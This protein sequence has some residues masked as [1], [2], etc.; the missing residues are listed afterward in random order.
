MSP[1]AFEQ[2]SELLGRTFFDFWLTNFARE[3]AR[4][5][6]GWTLETDHLAK[7]RSSLLRALGKPESKR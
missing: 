5:P 6:T 1:A 4:F 2:S 3:P 7:T